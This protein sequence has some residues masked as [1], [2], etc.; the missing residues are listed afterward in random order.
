LLRYQIPP[1]ERARLGEATTLP[2]ALSPDGRHLAFVATAEGGHRQLWIRDLDTLV[3]R[4]LV[5]TG[6]AA[7]PFWSPDS[8]VVGFA[9]G[10]KLE[11][12]DISGGGPP[13]TICDVTS[14]LGALGGSW[15]QDGVIVFGSVQGVMRVS[16]A[17]GTP[18]PVTKLD[19]SR[20]EAVHGY[21][22][23]LPDGRRF[24]YERYPGPAAGTYLGSLDGGGEQ[25]GSTPLVASYRAV[26]APV[27]GQGAG[28]LLFVQNGALIAQ[29][30]DA[31]RMELE[32]DPAP[33]AQQ[34]T[35]IAVSANGVL[36]Y[37]G[38]NVSPMQL[39]WFD[40]QGKVL[41]TLG[42]PGVSPTWPAISPDGSA[43]VVPRGEAEGTDLWVYS[44]V[45]GTQSRLTFDGKRNLAP[46]WSPDGS[47]IA[48]LSTRDG[49]WNIYQK[50]INGIG[51]DEV[52]DK[53]PPSVKAP[54]D[55]SRDGKYLIEGVYVDG[56]ASIWVLPLPPGTGR[57][58]SQTFSLRA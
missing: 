22:S 14:P 30:F 46:V 54:R 1:P 29:A 4:P 24:L 16:A 44:L 7:F 20:G 58:R 50:S 55:W 12:S 13:Q 25:P 43:V 33:I 51:Q 11:R 32:G 17:G 9:V 6:D 47:H 38:G 37:T 28:H 10:T 39:T 2:L 8:R 35:G 5:G 26:Y 27:S 48:F 40:R 21:P 31:S 18:A 45:R 23:F 42:E 41:G 3:S 56:K 19:T 34:V 49:S 36:A 15:N 52:L 57:R 53:N